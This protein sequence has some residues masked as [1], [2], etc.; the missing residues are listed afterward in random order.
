MSL[1]SPSTGTLDGSGLRIAIAAARF[2]EA[3]VDSLLERCESALQEAGC[4]EVLVERVPG[5]AELPFAASLLAESGGFE[6]V[7]ALGVVIAGDTNHHN[8]IG[9]STANALQG[10]AIETGI[11]V[12]NGILVVETSEQAEARCHGSIDRGKEFAHGALAM[13]RLKEKW[14]KKK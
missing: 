2:N 14:T 4:A 5:S 9:D 8:V 12:I 7:I 11:P 10:I 3:L 1:D 6:A 13:A